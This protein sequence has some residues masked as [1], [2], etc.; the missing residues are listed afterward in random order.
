M[1]IMFI[2]YF[3]TPLPTYLGPPPPGDVADVEAQQESEELGKPDVVLPPLLESVLEP[4][5]AALCAGQLGNLSVESGQLQLGAEEVGVELV[6]DLDEVVG[7][8]EQQREREN[9]FSHSRDVGKVV[10][11]G[12]EPPAKVLLPWSCLLCL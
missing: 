1:N 9:P 11:S 5:V 3:C 4:S 8:Q 10:K 6:V 7:H 12:Y 2:I